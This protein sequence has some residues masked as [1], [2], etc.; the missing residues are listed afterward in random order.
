MKLGWYAALTVSADAV[1]VVVKKKLRS[2]FLRMSRAIRL[3]ATLLVF[4]LTNRLDGLLNFP[5]IPL[6]DLQMIRREFEI[7]IR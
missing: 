2:N 6:R 3:R 5:D 4:R 7:V 1:S